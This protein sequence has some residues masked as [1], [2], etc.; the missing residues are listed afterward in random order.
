M[1]ALNLLLKNLLKSVDHVIELHR[2]PTPHVH[3]GVGLGIVVYGRPDLP[4]NVADVVI[5]TPCGP[6]PI[7]RNRLFLHRKTGKLMD[8]KVG[9]LLWPIH[10]EK[11]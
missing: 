6:L 2:L 8:G 7:Y 10:G 5:I 1:I 4:D 3:D 11:S 9:P